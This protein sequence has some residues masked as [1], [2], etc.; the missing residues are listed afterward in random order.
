MLELHNTGTLPIDMIQLEVQERK[1]NHREPTP[2]PYELG[3]PDKVF[4]WDERLLAMDSPVL[5][6]P[7][8]QRIRFPVHILGKISS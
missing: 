8:G 4:Q 3:E 7:P 5:P 1:S 2:S 6:L